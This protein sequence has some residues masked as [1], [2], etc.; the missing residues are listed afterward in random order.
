[1]Q[2]IEICCNNPY[3]PAVGTASIVESLDLSSGKAKKKE[4]IALGEEEV[5]TTK[6]ITYFKFHKCSFRDVKIQIDFMN[7]LAYINMH[8]AD[9]TGL[10]QGLAEMDVRERLKFEITTSK[11]YKVD[12]TTLRIN[13]FKN[14]LASLISEVASAKRWDV[15]FEG[16]E[17]A[18]WDM[19]TRMWTLQPSK[20]RR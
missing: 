12:W 1:M 17:G 19:S 10:W 8:N 20:I 7:P 18:I 11:E 16:N 3:Q 6:A 14:L 15:V 13:F 9:K 5:E 2:R 4:N